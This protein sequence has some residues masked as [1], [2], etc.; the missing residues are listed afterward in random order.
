MKQRTPLHLTP[1]E[2]DCDLLWSLSHFKRDLPCK[3]D[4]GELLLK[5]HTTGVQNYLHNSLGS[6]AMTLLCGNAAQHLHPNPQLL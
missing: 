5:T 4:V 3:G 6:V 1:S 2:L